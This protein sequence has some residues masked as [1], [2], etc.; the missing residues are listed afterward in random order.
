MGYY[1]WLSPHSAPSR[2][3]TTITL[4]LLLVVVHSVTLSPSQSNQT[5]L[6]RLGDALERSQLN[7]LQLLEVNQ[8]YV[9]IW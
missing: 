2:P 1:R 9:H 3:I 6:G 4:L 5:V 7:A 8:L